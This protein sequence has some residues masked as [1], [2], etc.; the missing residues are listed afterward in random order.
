[1]KITNSTLPKMVRVRLI[2]EFEVAA[3]ISRIDHNLQEH[4]VVIVR[5][6]KAKNLPLV[7]HT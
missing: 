3:H 1:M 2:S 6:G 4:N 5:W 7:Y